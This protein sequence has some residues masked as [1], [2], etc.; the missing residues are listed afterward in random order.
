MP[1]FV[2]VEYFLGGKCKKKYTSHSIDIYIE[3]Y[4]FKYFMKNILEA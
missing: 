3:P 4:N 1:T 2:Y